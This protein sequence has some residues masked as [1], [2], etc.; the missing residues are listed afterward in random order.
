MFDLFSVFQTVGALIFFTLLAAV[1]YS[2][3]KDSEKRDGAEKDFEDRLTKSESANV[4]LTKSVGVLENK[5]LTADSERVAMKKSYEAQIAALKVDYE[6]QIASLKAKMATRDTDHA[7]DRAKLAKL[8]SDMVDLYKRIDEM[9][10]EDTKKAKRIDDLTR[11]NGQANGLLLQEKTRSNALNEVIETALKH[12]GATFKPIEL[13][14]ET[15]TDGSI[16]N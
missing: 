4:K 8:T 16:S 2:Q 1:K 6:A 5:L 12:F 11:A 3:R 15:K 13:I 7:E 14:E 10:L 9:E